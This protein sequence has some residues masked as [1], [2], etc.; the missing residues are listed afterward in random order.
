M[1][2][3]GRRPD[4]SVSGTGG[5][6]QTVSNLLGDHPLAGRIRFRVTVDST[7]VW[8]REDSEAVSGPAVYIADHQTAGRG[9]LGREWIDVP[10][11]NLLVSFVITGVHEARRGLSPL[12]AAVGVAE[13]IEE[14]L[15]GLRVGLKWPNDLIVKDR[16]IGGILSEL[17]GSRED[18]RII[19]GIGLN[20]NQMSFPDELRFPAS[21]LALLCGREVSREHLLAGL[22][23][24]AWNRLSPGRSVYAASEL[25]SYRARLMGIGSRVHFH[26]NGHDDVSGV[27]LGI[28]DDGAVRI[29][30]DAGILDLNAGEISTLHGTTC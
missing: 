11:Q 4:H 17:V 13:A 9:R 26:R 3:R 25:E 1:Y 21:S 5:F 18:A 27:L 2:E 29:A 16:K 10:G 8:A 19:V 20:V 22:I 28:A 6:L 24:H 12:L 14:M 23:R 30:T 15:P 7:N